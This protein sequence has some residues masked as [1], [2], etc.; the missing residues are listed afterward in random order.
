MADFNE[1]TTCKRATSFPISPKI[2]LLDSNIYLWEN[3]WLWEIPLESFQFEFP[4]TI[5]FNLYSKPHFYECVNS[6]NRHFIRQWYAK[7]KWLTR[8]GSKVLLGMS[9]FF[10]VMLCPLQPE[11]VFEGVTFVLSFLVIQFLGKRKKNTRSK[12]YGMLKSQF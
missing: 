5:I 6:I 3:L 9:Q 4:P 10:L 11:L 12:L 7:T 1:N 2:E 8:R